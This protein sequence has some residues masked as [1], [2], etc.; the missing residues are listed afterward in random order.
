V[1]TALILVAEVVGG[2][3]T[4]SLALLSNAAHAFMDVFALT[5]SF[6]ALRLSALPPNDHHTYGYH[7]LEVLA[8]LINGV[9]LGVIAI[10][11]FWEAVAR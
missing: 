7:R 11:M 1:L 10:G 4:G 3:W 9:T 8:A 6:V 5:L 2:I